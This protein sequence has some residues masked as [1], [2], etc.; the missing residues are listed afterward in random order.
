MRVFY[1]KEIALDKI[2]GP[3][4]DSFNLLYTYKA[5]VEKTSP[6]SVVEIDHQTVS[7]RVKGKTMKKECFRRFLFLSRLVGEGLGLDAGLI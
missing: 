6:G 2:Y 4:K 3:W 5:E 7:Y 1:G